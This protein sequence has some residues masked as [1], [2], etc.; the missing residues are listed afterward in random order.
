MAHKIRL[1]KA[2]IWRIFLIRL[3]KHQ[4]TLIAD[5][6]IPFTCIFVCK[7]VKIDESH[8]FTPESFECY[9]IPIRCD[10]LIYFHHLPTS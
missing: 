4:S 3:T 10:Q 9:Q 6:F 7:R 1:K 5:I 8:V 2:T